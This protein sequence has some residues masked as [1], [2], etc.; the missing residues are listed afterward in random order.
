MQLFHYHWWTDKVEEMERFYLESG[1]KTTLRVG[2]YNGE[3][4]TFNPPLNWEDFRDKNIRFRIIEMVKGQ[5]NLTFGHGKRDMFDH[6]GFLVTEVEYSKVI[7]RAEELKWKVNE[8]ERRTFIST[9]WKFRIELQKRREVVTQ[10]K[11]PSIQ[12]MEI[13]M[14]FREDPALVSSLLN[15]ELIEQTGGNVTIGNDECTLI[16]CNSEEKEASL[17][18]VAYLADDDFSNVDPVHTKLIG[19][20]QRWNQ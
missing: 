15:F 16:F 19:R 8:G 13:Q 3:M 6:I 5:T 12:A 20:T 9:P 14:P 18:T 11:Q 4:H 7:E 1:F 10:E 2:R 17:H